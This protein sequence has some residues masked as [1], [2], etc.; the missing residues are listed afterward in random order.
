MATSEF[1]KAFRAARDAGDKTFMFNG[2]SYSTKMKDEVA[3]KTSMKEDFDNSAERKNKADTVGFYKK[4]LDESDTPN[5]SP[6][7]RKALQV[8]LNKAQSDYN[9]S[10]EGNAM[11]SAN[12]RSRAPSS[13]EGMKKGG[14]IKKMAAGG[15]ASSRGDG[16]AQRG[17][18]RGKYL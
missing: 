15:S 3:P 14:K 4:T 7:A 5:T 10:D 12:Y 8:N 13:D 6:A 9:S 17:K 16:I 2:K 18:T 1:G 11:T